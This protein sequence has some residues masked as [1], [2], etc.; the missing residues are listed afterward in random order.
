[1][2]SQT[3]ATPYRL[4]FIG[5]GKLAGSVVR[6]LVRARYCAPGLI[7][8]SE[9]NETTRRG[10]EHEVGVSGTAENAEVAEKSA[11]IFL[12]VKP[13]V[14]L[15]ILTELAPLLERKH[16][17][18]L[19]AGVGVTSMEKCAAGHFMRAMTNTPAAICR[20]APY[21]FGMAGGTLIR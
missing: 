16:V 3:A 9:P 10:L 14:V 21:D 4:G 2:D 1:M 7:L 13:G 15:P 19:A 11:V 6:G 18:S 12:G 5:G 20:A 17:I 8:V